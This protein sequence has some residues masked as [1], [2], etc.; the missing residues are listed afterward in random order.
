MRDADWFHFGEHEARAEGG[1]ADKQSATSG[2]AD[3]GL[4]ARNRPTCNDG[5]AN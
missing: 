4:L 5:G 2:H 3:G 1:F